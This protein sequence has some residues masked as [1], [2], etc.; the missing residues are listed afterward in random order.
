MRGLLGV[1]ALLAAPLLAL[2]CFTTSAAGAGAAAS[3]GTSL[4]AAK[5]QLPHGAK[6]L[7]A[8]SPSATVSGAVVLQP[9]DESGLTRFISQ[10]TDKHSPLFHQYLTPSEYAAKFGPTPASI[11]AVEAQL[12][13]SGLTVTKVARD[14]LV[15]GFEAPA[16]RV[17]SAFGTS[18]ERYKLASGATGRARTA[19]IRVPNTIARY[20]TSVVGLDTTVKL[21]S[22]GTIRAPKSM[23]GKHAAAK[24]PGFLHPA[25]SP[26]ACSDATDAAQEFGGLTDDQVANAYGAFGLY[27]AGDPGAGQHIAVFELEPFD[28]TDLQTFNTCYFG[29]TEAAAMASRLHIV[30]VDGGQTAGPGGG[31]AILDVQDA[32]AFAPGAN[33][34]VYEAPN[35][36]FGSFDEYLQIVNDNK[37]QVVTT[38]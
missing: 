6:A 23:V 27:N 34:D 38:S 15:V 35:T 36:T 12:R 31:E 21:H 19:P 20:V 17:E 14:G 30:P 2:V 11:A 33:I 22:A 24:A 3:T 8:V 26:T 18:L 29:A 32:S 5:P 7:G 37:D 9:R 13:A 10:V 4:M 1:R 28:A 16:N 25:G